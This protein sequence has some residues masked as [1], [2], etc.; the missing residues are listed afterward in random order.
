MI[1]TAKHQKLLTH[2]VRIYGRDA[3]CV[4]A[5]R[6]RV[7]RSV[8]RPSGRYR[9]ELLDLAEE[10]EWRT[11]DYRAAGRDHP[12]HRAKMDAF[13][14]RFPRRDQQNDEHLLRKFSARV[15]KALQLSRRSARIVEAY[16]KA[17]ALGRRRID[18]EAA[19]HPARRKPAP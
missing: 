18:I 7:R 9:A 2:L 19:L 14:R 1:L 16:E 8:G 6:V 17:V 12:Q 3:I 15:K 4:A 5:K 10:I 13:L 11:A